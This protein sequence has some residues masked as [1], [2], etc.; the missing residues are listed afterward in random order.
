MFHKLKSAG[1]EIVCIYQTV[2]LLLASLQQ[3]HDPKIVHPSN[4][5][6]TASGKTHAEPEFDNPDLLFM[7]H[8]TGPKV[9]ASQFVPPAK[10]GAQVHADFSD[11]VFCQRK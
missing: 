5:E 10:F 6:H 11:T 8:D 4:S 9:W 7:S 1:F 3:C 2:A